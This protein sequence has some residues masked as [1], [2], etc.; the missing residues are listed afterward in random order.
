MERNVV[1]NSLNYWENS[2]KELNNF[3]PTYGEWL[4]D[5]SEIITKCETPIIDLGCGDGNTTYYLVNKGKKVIACDQSKYSIINTKNNVKNIYDTK[6]FNLL[7]GLPFLNNYT[8]L[9]IADLSLHYFKEADTFEIL[10]EI[11]RILKP[12]GYLIFRVNSIED[13]NFGSNGDVET[14]KHLYLYNNKFLKRF[15]DKDDI[16]HFFKDFKIESLEE[17]TIMKFN[18]EKNET[19][20]KNMYKVCVRNIKEA[21]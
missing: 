21:K 6:C 14:E 17:S 2:Y 7:D 11:K 8:D 19:L 13:K 1:E 9:I 20:P 3:D 12:N 16:Y 5:F 10:N 18:K 15:F 4:N